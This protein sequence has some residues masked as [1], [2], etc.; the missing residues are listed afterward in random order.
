MYC[1]PP[2]NIMPVFEQQLVFVQR[3]EQLRVKNVVGFSEDGKSFTFEVELKPNQRYQSLVT[4]RFRT[5]NGISL[6]TFLIDI[7]TANK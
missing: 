1:I 3:L 7:T 2:D 4:N 6:K 5:I